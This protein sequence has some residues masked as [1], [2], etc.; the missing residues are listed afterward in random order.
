MV[1]YVIYDL[2]CLIS[3]QVSET[4]TGT[5]RVDLAYADY[6]LS[7]HAGITFFVRQYGRHLAVIDAGE[8]RELVNHLK[9]YWNSGNPGNTSPD[10]AAENLEFRLQHRSLWDPDYDTFFSMPFTDRFNFLLHQELTE[11]FGKEFKWVKRLPFILKILYASLA[12]LGKY[13]A[14]FLLRSGQFIG[15][16]L[17]RRNLRSALRIIKAESK[18]IITLARKIQEN[19]PD[20][21]D[22]QYLYFYTAYNRGFPF[23]ALESL[24]RIAD[25]QLCIFIHDLIIINYPEYFL[26]VNHDGQKTW[27]KR[28]L[29]LQPHII[30]NSYTTKSLIEDFAREHRRSNFFINVAHIGVEPCFR[31]ARQPDVSGDKCY[32]VVIAT[33]EPRKNHLLLLN[34]WREL[35]GNDS[36]HAPDLYIVG[37]R[38]WENENIVD[39]LQRCKPIQ[40]YVHE[41]SEM[42]DYDLIKLLQGSRALLYPSFCEGWGMPVVEALTLGV[43]VICSDIP[44][45][46]ESGQ[47]IPDYY[48]PLDGIGWQSAIRDFSKTDSE[49]RRK[50]LDRIKTF[51]PPAW[52]NHFRQVRMEFIERV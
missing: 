7:N 22:V 52:E 21:R 17:Y 26:P 25:L 50:Q 46:R 15:V 14:R 5:M 51:D 3:Q 40:R 2:T 42:N 10:V 31:Q 35:A 16:F 44:E 20:K 28:L 38:G 49:L 39:M 30:A 33:I 24:G 23:E 9:H 34:I 47:N 36:E 1:R 43:P 37:K 4:P 32:F 45:L 41:V 19:T 13:P 6:L 29:S 11:I 18:Q 48:S 12:S 27:L 8:V